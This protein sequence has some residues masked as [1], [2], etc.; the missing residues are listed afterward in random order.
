[1][2]LLI[3]AGIE[4][5]NLIQKINELGLKDGAIVYYWYWT[6][7]K[8]WHWSKRYFHL[9]HPLFGDNYPYLKDNLGGNLPLLWNKGKIK[10][11]DKILEF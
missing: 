11:N 2:S 8:N 9:D 7:N 6:P 3:K 5:T 10:Y 4:K 1:M